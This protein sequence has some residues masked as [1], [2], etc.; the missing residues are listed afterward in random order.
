MNALFCASFVAGASQGRL[1]CCFG[2][3]GRACLAH[4]SSWYL[5]EGKV[6]GAPPVF[7][8]RVPT[9]PHGNTAGSTPHGVF[10]PSSGP[11]GLG[12]LSL[13]PLLLLPLGLPGG[14]PARLPQVAP[15][16]SVHTGGE[17]QRKLAQRVHRNSK[18]RT[19]AALEIGATAL[20][21]GSNLDVNDPEVSQRF[22]QHRSVVHVVCS[23]RSSAHDAPSSAFHVEDRAVENILWL[24]G[25]EAC[26]R[27]SVLRLIAV[28]MELGQR[29][30]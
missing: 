20:G 4:P 1:T 28:A 13:P 29:L 26:G 24:R 12:P 19:R 14:R 21:L 9:I 10:A 23:R 17:P 16:P 7:R 22:F 15:T 6:P 3:S 5:S 11:L 8:G 25:C 2:V 30:P 27:C 18:L